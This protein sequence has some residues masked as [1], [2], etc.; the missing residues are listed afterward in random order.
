MDHKL[1]HHFL[2]FGSLS[3]EEIAAIDS[4][5]REKSFP[6]GALLLKAGQ[7]SNEVFFVLEGIVRQYYLIDGSEKTSEFFTEG[8]WVL[9]NNNLGQDLPSG[10]YLECS[11]DCLLLVGNS[12][13]G[14]ELYSRY[15][16]L[17]VISRKL[18]E[19]VFLE[20]QSKIETFVAGSPQG[21]Y[22]SLLRQKPALF[23]QVPLYHIASYIGVTPESLS[24]IRKRIR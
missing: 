10:H 2:Q 9:S 16:N 5:M 20:Q 14:E 1:L 4:T 23:Q 15:P 19:A 22:L 13:K 24:R 3:D 11:S 6:K 21:R 7:H 8:Q 17:G 18:M 12:T